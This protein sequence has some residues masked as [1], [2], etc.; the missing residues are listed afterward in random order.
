[1]VYP[2]RIECLTV[3]ADKSSVVFCGVVSCE[4]EGI[5]EP[6]T[7]HLRDIAK[8]NTLLGFNQGNEFFEFTIED[9]FIFYK[10]DDIRGAKFM[11]NERPFRREEALLKR[12]WFKINDEIFSAKVFTEDIKKS[13]QATAFASDS[14]KVYLYIEDDAFVAELNDETIANIDSVKMNYS[15]FFNGSFSGKYII[16]VDSLRCIPLPMGGQVLFQ[17]IEKTSDVLSGKTLYCTVSD[18]GCLFRYLLNQWRD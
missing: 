13:I 15:N 16:K 4:T 18:E 1:M 6:V 5:A 14:D 9:S 10:N 11:L 8:L 7:L 17:M 2:N 3:S 12:N